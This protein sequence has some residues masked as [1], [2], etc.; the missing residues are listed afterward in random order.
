MPRGSSCHTGQEAWLQQ[1][2][3]GFFPILRSAA[4]APEAEQRMVATLQAVLQAVRGLGGL[5]KTEL[6]VQY[7]LQ[8]LGKKGRYQ[9]VFFVVVPR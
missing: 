4:D 1:L 7:A 2:F 3:D 5:G 6:A 8:H 9:C